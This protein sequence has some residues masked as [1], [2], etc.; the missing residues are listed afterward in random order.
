MQTEAQAAELS[1]AITNLQQAN[2]LIE[3]RT[4]QGTRPV[5]VAPSLADPD[6][7]R[8]QQ[9]R[10]FHADRV[11]EAKEL[12]EKP[13][14]LAQSRDEFTVQE[15]LDPNVRRI[16][17]VA[18]SATEG[19]RGYKLSRQLEKGYLTEQELIT[20]RDN[21]L[22][23]TVG[24]SFVDALKYLVNNSRNPFEKLLATNIVKLVQRMESAGFNFDY[25]IVDVRG[26]IQPQGFQ[27]LTTV[28]NNNVVVSLAATNDALARDNGVNHQTL[29]HEGVHAV[30][31]AATSAARRGRLPDDIKL[32]QDIKDLFDLFDAVKSYFNS[33]IAELDAGR[34]SEEELHPIV[35][36]Y[37]KR[38]TTGSPNFLT[39]GD[40][41]LAWGLTDSE[42]QDFLDTVPYNP[43]TGEV[44]EGKGTITLWEALVNALRKLLKLPPKDNTALNELLRVQ[45]NLLAP[46]EASLTAV[47]SAYGAGTAASREQNPA[48]VSRPEETASQVVDGGLKSIPVLTSKGVQRVQG[49][50]LRLFI[51][52]FS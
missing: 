49:C 51:N 48:L 22:K 12:G 50:C 20:E 6:N 8:T 17:G 1:E 13:P 4:S 28:A 44:G 24:K 43:R 10:E 2:A 45:N 31:L 5:R 40:E 41:L 33:Q 32:K 25:K 37:S 36:T 29:L 46:D 38:S 52:R 21:L 47:A 26:N 16:E 3:G 35:S 30:T 23:G 18:Y 27:G 15:G 39:D 14:T 42:M 7:V 19:G 34:V 11:T 9:I